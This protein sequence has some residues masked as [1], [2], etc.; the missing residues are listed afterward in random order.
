MIFI[1]VLHCAHYTS[2]P[3]CVLCLCIS[4]QEFKT[5][6]QSAAGR[7][8]C[9]HKPSVEGRFGGEGTL[10]VCPAPPCPFLPRAE[11]HAQN[12]KDVRPNTA[13]LPVFWV[14]QA[15]QPLARGAL[16]KAQSLRASAIADNAPIP[17]WCLQDRLGY[18]CPDP[19]PV[20]P[21]HP[22][23]WPL[24]PPCPAVRLRLAPF[25]VPR[26][27]ATCHGHRV[28]AL[29]QKSDWHRRT[30]N[31]ALPC[32]CQPAYLIAP[33]QLRRSLGRRAWHRLPVRGRAD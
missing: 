5:L 20:L 15:R 24:P 28:A 25:A 27:S 4:R 13:C 9:R 21:S 26:R 33:T 29:S 32:P 19:L 22:A 8:V 30:R 10:P 31:L 7:V 14:L 6:V 1:G 23:Q 18:L 16:A 11:G 2:L 17:A 3:Q 12:A